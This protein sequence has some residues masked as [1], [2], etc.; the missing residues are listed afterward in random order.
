MMDVI[1]KESS[2]TMV[3]LTEQKNVHKGFAFFKNISFIMGTGPS[4]L[5]LPRGRRPMNVKRRST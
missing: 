3:S 4:V 1:A 2:R 5:S